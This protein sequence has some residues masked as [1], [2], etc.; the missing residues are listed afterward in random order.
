MMHKTKWTLATCAAVGLLA[1][2]L[3]WSWA[4]GAVPAPTLPAAE[5][6]RHALPAEVNDASFERFIDMGGAA[7]GPGRGRPRWPG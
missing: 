6:A 1:T 7:H 4:T 5:E 3:A 2:G